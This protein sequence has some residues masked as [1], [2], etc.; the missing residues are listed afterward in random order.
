MGGGGGGACLPLLSTPLCTPD[1][2]SREG[3]G[4]GRREGEGE[5]EGRKERQHRLE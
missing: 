2:R 3:G 1:Q 4:E 5:R